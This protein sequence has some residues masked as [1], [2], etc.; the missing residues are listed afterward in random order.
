MGA[1]RLHE[2]QEG[3]F[4]FLCTIEWSITN[5]STPSEFLEIWFCWEM[6]VGKYPK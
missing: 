6:I 5:S 1:R 2:R 3:V 4:G